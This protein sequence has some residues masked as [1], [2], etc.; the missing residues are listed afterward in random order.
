MLSLRRSLRRIR[1]DLSAFQN[2]DAYVVTAIGIVLLVIDVLGDVPI[3]VQL[4]VIVAA[5]VVLVF[6]STA[7]PTRPSDVND[8]LRDRSQ[9]GAYREFIRGG[10]TLWIYAPSAINVLRD[11]API[12]EEILD[13]GGQLWV[14]LQ[15]PH[16][17]Y[18]VENL[19]RQLDIASGALQNDIFTSLDILR[20]L[21]QRRDAAGYN[22]EYG[23]VSYSPGF[24]LTI[25]DA[26]RAT[27]RLVVEFF[28][29]HN[30]FIKDRMHV[31]ITRQQ[32]EYWFEYWVGQFRAMADAATTEPI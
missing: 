17:R 26:E 21:T 31:E 11:P 6:R 29:Y 10:R 24:S 30:E 9:F 5:L 2:I 28:G 14:L 15:N 1:R 27:G 20:K 23:F 3:D 22:I 12:K 32:S 8:V 19:V 13:R 18:V 7:P 4:T 16:E 25:V